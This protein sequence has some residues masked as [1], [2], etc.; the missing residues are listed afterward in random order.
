[1]P[2]KRNKAANFEALA[3]AISGGEVAMVKFLWSLLEEF[4][5]TK[6]VATGEEII[7][8]RGE[9]DSFMTAWKKNPPKDGRTPSKTELKSLIAPLIPKPIPGTNAKPPSKR[10]LRQLIAPLIPDPIPGK[11]GVSPK[12]KRGLAGSIPNHEWRG[13]FIRF[14]DPDGEWGEYV[15]LQGSAAEPGG[16]FGGDFGGPHE[17]PVK[18][19]DN[20]SI[21][22]DAS[23]AQVIS[24]D[25]TGSGSGNATLVRYETPT[26]TVNDSNVSFTVTEIPLYII[27]NGVQYF[28]DQGY[29]RAGLVITLY[30]PVGTGNWIKSAYES[31][32]VETPG[33]TVNDA[34]V[35]FT[36][37]EIPLFI[38]VNGQ[39]LFEGAGY[40]RAT[41]TLTLDNPVGTG[42]FIRSVFQDGINNESPTGTVDDSNTIFTVDNEPRYVVVNG[43]LYF[44]GK[45]YAYTAGSID[46][47]YA[48]GENGFIRSV[49]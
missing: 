42:G 31:D 6:G 22:K 25:A 1:M 20:I 14:Q 35:T 40:S 11:P 44:D 4:E 17:L 46:L 10:E 12:S 30:N 5:S 32:G 49:Y 28:E 47:T 2:L 38:V 48:V 21:R 13:T 18:A 16:D 24:S 43:L 39:K 33:G 27:V 8:M 15:N 36:V 3:K 26:G 34:N 29:G 19:G 23:G 41:L 7:K 45:G 9:I 37:I